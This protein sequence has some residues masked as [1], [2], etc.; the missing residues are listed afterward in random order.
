MRCRQACAVT[1][2]SSQTLLDASELT[3][4]SDFNQWKAVGEAVIAAR[5]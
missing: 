1:R 5:H 3:S 2:L 4:T